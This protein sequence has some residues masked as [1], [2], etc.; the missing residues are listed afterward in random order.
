MKPRKSAACS[1]DMKINLKSN[2]WKFLPSALLVC[3]CNTAV[4]N[5]PI[6]TSAT[7]APAQSAAPVAPA[8]KSHSPTTYDI[9]PGANLKTP[10]DVPWNKL[11]AGDTVLIHWR[12]EPYKNKWVIA[13]E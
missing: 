9:G 2:W 11:Q 8:E 12:S 5:V 7:A 10:N 6:E 13:V 1:H 3:A 4:V